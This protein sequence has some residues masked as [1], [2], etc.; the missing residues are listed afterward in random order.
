MLI[1]TLFS[2]SVLRLFLILLSLSLTDLNM[3]TDRIS[4][5]SH[6][7][8]LIWWFHSLFTSRATSFLYV[9]NFPL[10]S[11]L[12]QCCARFSSLTNNIL[13]I[14]GILLLVCS[15]WGPQPLWMF[16]RKALISNN[17]HISRVGNRLNA[18]L[19]RNTVPEALYGL[20][21]A[22]HTRRTWDKF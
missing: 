14:P 17:P 18:R 11:N 15:T 19:K 21:N 7:Q 8:P 6:V 20:I 10:I 16:M 2:S 9:L 13:I 5:S 1:I 12:Q 3:R 22:L 4:I